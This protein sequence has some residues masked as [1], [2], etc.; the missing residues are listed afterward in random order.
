MILD[1]DF[2]LYIGIVFS[3]LLFVLQNQ[4]FKKINNSTPNF[5]IQKIRL[6]KAKELIKNKVANVTEIAFKV[7]FSSTTYFS[8]S[9][10]KE[11]GVTP[12]EYFNQSEKT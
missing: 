1:V 8:Y 3:L 10:K 2:G 7:G 4:R 5:Y 6:E 11:F 12:K 9:F